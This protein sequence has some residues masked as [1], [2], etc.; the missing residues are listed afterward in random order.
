[1]PNS[2]ALVAAAREAEA[3]GGLAARLRSPEGRL[4][5][6][7]HVYVG[8]ALSPY[9]WS[10]QQQIRMAS[11]VDLTVSKYDDVI[12]LWTPE[13]KSHAR[14]TVVDALRFG[15]SVVHVLDGVLVP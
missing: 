2:T 3:Q 14:I 8:G 5:L 6:L 1:M 13:Q 10:N 12:E 9:E 4:Q 15:N 7:T 11:G